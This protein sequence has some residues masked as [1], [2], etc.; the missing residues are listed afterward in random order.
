MKTTYVRQEDVKRAWHLV[1]AKDKV[2]GRLAT[3]I[4]SLLKGKQKVA[5]APHVDMGDGVVVINSE[6]IRVTGKK[7]QQKMYKRF[8]GYPG[9]LKLESLESLFKR[10]PHEILRYAV[11]GMLPKNKLGR[12]MIKR[13]K[14]YA[15]D[16]HKHIAQKPK[17]IKL[18]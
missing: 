13:L 4:A 14:I 11:K 6:K 5:Y 18:Y 12:L 7:P 8:S 17:K 15:G 2:L 16:K 1:D 9:G 3:R 10:R